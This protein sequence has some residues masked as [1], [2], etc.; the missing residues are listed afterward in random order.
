MKGCHGKF[1]S[2]KSLEYMNFSKKMR[3]FPYIHLLIS[4]W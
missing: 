3:H 2:S 4:L 1:L